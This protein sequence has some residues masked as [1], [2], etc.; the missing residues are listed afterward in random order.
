M[1]TATHLTQATDSIESIIRNHVRPM[2]EQC[3][4][5]IEH[6]RNPRI[7]IEERLYSAHHELAE[8]IETLRSEISAS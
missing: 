4:E 6:A 8:R 2:I 7:I 3:F 1:R 5:A